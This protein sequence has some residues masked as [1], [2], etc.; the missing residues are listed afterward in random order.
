M[1]ERTPDAELERYLRRWVPTSRFAGRV[2]AVGGYVRDELLGLAP[3]DLD[4]A[5]EE[6][7]GAEKLARA[8]ASSTP[9]F[10][11]PHALGAGYPIWQLVAQDDIEFEGEVY[12]T[13]GAELEIA[14]TQS[15]AFPD[16]VSRQRVT[17]YGNLREDCLRRDFT[18]NMLYRD[19]ATGEIVDPSGTGVADL[20]AGRLRGHPQASLDKIFSD[21]PLRMIRLVR[22]HCR[23]GWAIDPEAETAVR[24]QAER[25]RILS[26]ERIRDEFFKI[27]GLGKLH[28]ALEWVRLHGL[29]EPLFPE[30]VPMVGCGQDQTWHS[31]GDVWVHTLLVISNSPPTVTLQLAA[32]LH[33]VG[34]P[35][36]RTVEGERVKF[37]GHEKISASLA[38]EFCRRLK[39][40]SRT[41]DVVMKLVLLH[42]RGGD[43]EGW[44]SLKPVRRLI[45]D[46]GD[47]LSHLLEL[48]AAD[49][50]SSYGVDGKPRLAHVELLKVK[51]TEAQ[52]I[53]VQRKPVIGGHEIMKILG[54]GPGPEIK[55]AQARL[56][57]LEDE[58]AERG[59]TL[60]PEAARAALAPKR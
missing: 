34:K 4:V 11:A 6:P 12:R 59:E 28:V 7:G 53:P 57:E 54:I 42:L 45:R 22:F 24:R 33:D 52:K 51:I 47:E 27:M 14:D 50:G 23:F 37:L 20:R 35:A 31:E 49:S 26:A 9:A 32:L 2:F 18:T 16:P 60:S 3:K 21:D 15:E 5:V 46:A 10:S 43:V 41:T 30:L 38:R 13:K 1:T 40:D 55:A 58:L 56:R 25:V 29:L 17:K 48:I 39:I 36:S 44:A 19:L 8:L